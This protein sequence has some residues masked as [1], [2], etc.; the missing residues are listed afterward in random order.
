TI[1]QSATTSTSPGATAPQG[2]GT[3]PLA[4]STPTSQSPTTPVTGASG[5]SGA[6]G[7]QLVAQLDLK[8]P[9]GAKSPV[10]VAQVVRQ[11][12]QEGIV[13]VATGVTANTKHNA[14]A[15]WLSSSASHVKLLGFVNPAVGSNGKP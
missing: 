4:S 7:T 10:G 11:G 9:S 6:N 12:K 13:I 5:A 15:V 2:T 1:A 14:Y 3:S 8:S